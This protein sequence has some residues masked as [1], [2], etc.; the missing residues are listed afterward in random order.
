MKV[1]AFN[2]GPRKKWNTATLLKKA[3]GAL[4]KIKYLDPGSYVPQYLTLKVSCI[5]P[6]YPAPRFGEGL[7]WATCDFPFPL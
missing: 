2:A 7:R 1:M 4:S 3:T 5:D 6:A